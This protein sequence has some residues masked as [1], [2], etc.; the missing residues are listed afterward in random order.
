M[1]LQNNVWADALFMAMGDQS[2]Q[3]TTLAQQALGTGIDKYRNKDYK[4]AAQEFKRALGLDPQSE[5]AIDATK[6]LAMSHERLGE[7]DKAIKTYVDALKVYRD[8]D[9]L[10]IA[11]GN[12]YYAEERIGE[13]IEAYEKAVR[14][15]DDPNNRFA[16]G[17][18][19]LKSGRHSDAADQFS[20]V[21][22]M[23]SKSPNGYFGLGQAYGAQKQYAD[24]ITQFE[25]AIQR[26]RQFYA[27]YAEIGY[28]HVDSGDMRKAEE[29]KS[30]LERKDAGLAETLGNYISQ[31][32]APK[33]MFA[34]AHSSFPFFMRP[35]TK[36]AA[37]NGYLSNANTSHNFS[38]IFQFSKEMDRESVENV[39]NWSI[40]RSS[41]NGAGRDYNFGMRVPDTEVRSPTMP[42]SIYYDAKEM[43]ATVRF[44]IRQNAD[45]NGTIDPSR[46]VFAFKGSDSDGNAMNPKFDQYM[47]F[48]GT[49]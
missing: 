30:D 21:I 44:S 34:Y 7:T 1:E 40:A 29:V 17:Q 16:L 38:M 6:Y 27:A 31:K 15:Y 9:E 10:Q 8:R 39:L 33:M 49:F 18:A 37:L 23:D 35:K 45:A 42:L 2:H 28:M 41:G 25:R 11:L 4:G 36:V 20:R 19:Y 47:G 32:T 43:T 3:L 24:A 13:A 26:N 48:S 46:L 12:I 5:Y 22:K 14:I